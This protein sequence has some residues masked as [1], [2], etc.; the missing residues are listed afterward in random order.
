MIYHDNVN[1]IINII[2][3]LLQLISSSV[4]YIFLHNRSSNF[5]YLSINQS[6]MVSRVFLSLLVALFLVCSMMPVDAQPSFGGFPGFGG[7]QAQTQ[8]NSAGLA[9]PAEPTSCMPMDHECAFLKA[10]YPCFGDHSLPYCLPCLR[11]QQCNN[12]FSCE[13]ARA[14]TACNSF[15]YNVEKP[16]ACSMLSC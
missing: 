15:T 10:C 9:Q 4:I 13:K 1:I 11:L 6:N 12:D 16:Q 5:I 2:I 3:V 7:Q 14:C 8:T